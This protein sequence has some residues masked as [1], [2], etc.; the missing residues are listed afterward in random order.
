[1]RKII[2]ITITLIFLVGGSISDLSARGFREAE[3]IQ[4]PPAAGTLKKI[5]PPAQDIIAQLPPFDK[6]AVQKAVHEL[7]SAWNE[8]TLSEYL[9]PGFYNKEK[10]LDA[11]SKSV[12]SDATLRILN[13]RNVKQ[14]KESVQQT[15]KAVE[16]I[17]SVSAT[18]ETQIEFDDPLTGFQRLPGTSEFIF[19][20]TET[21]SS[22]DLY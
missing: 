20:I 4:K 6:K 11:I 10:L 13:V 18:V 14:L 5:K 9:D 22:G 19:M 3:R 7:A 16:R 17:S 1:M 8:G 2:F 15:G 12:P 21:F